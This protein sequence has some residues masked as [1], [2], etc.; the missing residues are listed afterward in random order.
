V[1]PFPSFLKEG[2]LCSV[3]G[4]VERERERERERDLGFQDKY[5]SRER[6]GFRVPRELRRERE[7]EERFLRNHE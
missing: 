4:H 3:V 1:Y 2:I 6:E 5:A 7:R